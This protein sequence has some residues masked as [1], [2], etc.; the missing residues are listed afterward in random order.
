MIYDDSVILELK[1]TQYS[2]MGN[3]QKTWKEIREIQTVM[4]SKSST[5][6]SGNEVSD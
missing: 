4:H 6:K 1:V 2:L 5:S 3:S